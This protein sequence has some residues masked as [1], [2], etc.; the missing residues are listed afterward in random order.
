METM[1]E[2]REY[3]EGDSFTQLLN[4]RGQ[5]L[6]KSKRKKL[7]VNEIFAEVWEPAKKQWID[8]CIKLKIG[9]LFFSD[10]RKHFQTDNLEK[11]RLELKKHYKEENADWIDQRIHQ[12]KQY[13]TIC[14]CLDG[15]KA[16][17]KI[18]R[19]YNLKGNF[20]Q[21]QDIMKLTGNANTKMKTLDEDLLKTCSVL[22]EVDS[23]KAACL[24]M[25]VEC[26]N[27]ILWLRQSMCSIK[28]L[29]VFVDLASTSTGEGDMAVARV[30]CLHSATT[31]YGP[32]IFNFNENCDDK[33]F[34]EKC[35]QV[36]RVL[37]TDSKL[38]KKLRGTY[39]NLE[40]LKSV[41]KSHGSV[42]V[43]S[44]A[45]AE[46]INTSGVYEVGYSGVDT[47]VKKLLLT[48]VLK[49]SVSQEKENDACKEELEMNS[50]ER[51]ETF[52]SK[53]EEKK[54]YNYQQLQDLQS[55]LML[56][57][58]KAEK[59][60]DEVERFT[61]ILDSVVRLG[62]IYTKLVSDGCVL[63]AN[64]KATFLCDKKRAV[65]VFINFGHGIQMQT[66]KG[67]TNDVSSIIPK[68]AE[69]LEHCHR[70]WLTYI[71]EKR[72]QHYLLNYYTIDQI[73][74]L[75]QELVKM[76]LEQNLTDLIYPMLSAVK[77]NCTKED[78]IKAL[79]MAKHDVIQKESSANANLAADSESEILAE[80]E[81]DETAEALL[82]Q[83]IDNGYPEELAREA[84]KHC[85]E[86]LEEALLWCDDHEDDNIIKVTQEQIDVVSADKL[87][88]ETPYSGWQNAF[89]KLHSALQDLWDKFLNSVSSSVS[90]YL[91]AEHLGLILERLAEQETVTIERT[92]PAYFKLGEPNLVIV[93][94][95]EIYNTCLSIYNHE[96]EKPLPQSDEVLLCSPSTTLDMVEIFWR[97]ALFAEN[98]KI[99]C[100][101]NADLLDY[102][103]A[104]R[105]ERNLQSLMTSLKSKAKKY[106]LVILCCAEN[107]NKSV[108]VRALCKFQRPQLFAVEI[109]NVKQYLLGMLKVEEPVHGIKPAAGV[110]FERHCGIR[111]PSWSELH[112]FVS[113]LDAQLQDFEVSSFCSSV[114]LQDLPGFPKFVLRFLIQMSRDF[115]TRS[116]VVSEESPTQVFQVIQENEPQEENDGIIE[117]YQMRRTWESSPHPYLFFNPDHHSMTFLGFNIEKGTGNLIDLQTKEVL[118][119]N[120]MEK[121][122]FDALIR[123]RVNLS[124]N[125]DS[126]PR[127]EKILKLCNVMGIDLAHDPDPTYELTTDNVKKILAIYMRFRCRIPVIIMGE[128]GC[129]KTR[130]IKFMCSLQQPPGVEVKNMILM[131]VHGGT[132]AC[133]IIRKVKQAEKITARNSKQH[134]N[135]DTVLFF[136][137][138][139]TTEAIGVIKEIMCDK[140]LG[141]KPMELHQRLKMVAACNPY[142]KHSK[143][144]IQ[145][146]EQAGLG[147]HV[148]AEKTTDKLGHVPMRNLVYR[149]QP[150]PQS[151]LPLVWDFGQLDT[152]VEELY[153]RQMVLRCV[154]NGHLPSL[155]GL[156]KIVSKILTVSQDFMRKQKDECSF[157]SLRDV[158]RVLQVMSWFY[159]QSQDE[160]HLL[161]NEIRF[162]ERKKNQKAG[163]ESIKDIEDK[164]KQR[165]D[166]IDDL[167]RSLVLALGVCYHACL[168]K[169][170]EYR[171]TVARH[172]KTPLNLP[173]GADQIEEEIL[174]CQSAFID[175]VELAQNI[176]KNKALKENVFMMIICIEL[177]IPMFLVGKPGSSKSLA[178]TIVADAMQ[179]NGAHN[180]L[181]RNFKQVQIVSFQCSP[182]STPDGI[183]GTFKQCAAYQKDK[184]G[185]VSVVVLDE[186]GLAEDSP[187]MPLKTLH[188]LLEDGCCD[189]EEPE[190]Y[191]KVAFV[192]IS[193]WALDP[194]KMN[195]GILVQRDIPDK[196]EL[197]NSARKICST[198]KNVKRIIDPMIDPL[199]ISY[200]ELF[201]QASEEMRE[202]FGLRDFYS[203]LKMLYGFISKSRSKPTWL[204]LK[205]CILRNFGGLPEE[206]I[207]PVDIFARNLAEVVNR[208]EEETEYDPECS[209]T[210]MIKACLSGQADSESRYLLLLTENYGALSILQQKI[211]SMHN[212]EVIFGSSFPSDQEYT[213][214]CR[215]INRIKVC[216]ETGSTVIL[217]NLEN[218]YESLYD[219]LNQYYVE[220]GGERYVDLG[221]GTHRV[222][223]RVHKKFRLVVVAEKQVVYDK[224][225]IP[226][227]NRLEKHFLS[228][229]TMLTGEQAELTEALTEWAETCAADKS[230]NQI[231][232]K[233]V[234]KKIGDTFIG[235]HADTCAA[236][237]H[238]ICEKRKSTTQTIH[239]EREQILKEGKSTLLW[240]A[241]PAAVTQNGGGEEME[242]YSKQQQH[243]SLTDY[244]C[245]RLQDDP[246]QSF[247]AQITTNSRILSQAECEDLCESIPIDRQNVIS[248]TLQQF[249]TEQQFSKQ[250]RSLGDSKTVSNS[251]LIVQCE[252]GD[253]NTE[254]I[255]CARYSIQRELKRILEENSEVKVHVVLLVQ[256]PGIA[257]DSFTGFQCGLWHS[258]HID[259]LRISTVIPP[260]C[261]MCDKSAGEILSS[262]KQ[263][264]KQTSEKVETLEESE[265]QTYEGDKY[266]PELFEQKEFH[267]NKF[268]RSCV[269]KALACLKDPPTDSGHTSGRTTE[270]LNI[271]LRLLE[272]SHEER[273]TVLSGIAEHTN[274]IIR[275]REENFDTTTSS[276]WLS[277]LASRPENITK[278]GTFR[279]CVSQFLESKVVPILAGII[280]FIDTNRN[281]DILIRNEEQKQKWQT[282]LWL[283]I[284]NDPELTQLNYT[285]IVS[286]KQQQELSEYVVK[287]TSSTGRVFSAVMPFSWL[288]YNQI[289]EVLV[290]TKKTLQESDDLINVALKAADIFQDFPLGRLLLSMEEVTTQDILRCYIRDFVFMVYPVQTEN[291]CNLICESVAIECKTLLRGE[292]GRLL[293]S[294]FG[295]HIVYAYQAARFQNFS[296]IVCVWPDCSEKV[297]DYQQRESKNFLVTDEENTL[298][299]LAL[300]LLIDDLKPVKDAL[301][302]PEPR[303]KWLQK[304]CQYRP[305]VERIFGHFKQ[306]VQNQEL[307]YGEQCQQGLQQARYRWTRTFIVKLFIENVCMSNEEEGKEVI[308]CMALWTK[309]GETDPDMKTLTTF[310]TIENYLKKRN[311]TVLS[312]C[313]GILSP[314]LACER[315]ISTL[316]VKLPC[317]DV[318]CEN[319]YR[320]IIIEKKQCIHCNETLPENFNPA[321]LHKS[322]NLTK[323]RD[324]RRRC[325]SF[326]M[327]VVS[328]LCF[329]EGTPPSPDV[330]KKLQSYII[331]K[332]KNERGEKLLVSKE[333]SVFQDSIDPTPVV[334][335][336]LLQQLMQTSGVNVEEHLTSYFE[337]TCQLVETIGKQEELV[338]LCLLILQCMED[339]I[340]QQHHQYCDTAKEI[341]I[342][343]KLMRETYNV[344]CKTDI[345]VLEKIKAIAKT[346]FALSI[347]ANYV[348][349]VF[350]ISQKGI[351]GDLRRLFETAGQLCEDCLCPWPRQ[352]FVKH[353][354]RSFG[355]DTYQAVQGSYDFLRWVQ[356]PDLKGKEVK[357]CHD[358]YIV[359][360]GKY[361]AIREAVVA[362][363]ISQKETELQKILSVQHTDEWRTR[364]MVVLALHRE[365]AMHNIYIDE[366]KF[367][368]KGYDLLK[369]C[370]LKHPS[371]RNREGLPSL[372]MT[373]KLWED[374]RFNIYSEM[375]L[376]QQNIICLLTHYMVLMMEIPGQTTLITPLKNIAL[377]PEKMVNAYYPTMPQDEALYVTEA[378]LQARK[379]NNE[380]P[381]LYKCPNGHPYIIGDCGRPYYK[382]KCNT[383][384]AQI[385]GV[386]HKAIPGN[387]KYEG[388]ETA[389]G[390]ILGRVCDRS[391][392]QAVIHDRSLDKETIILIRLL[393]HMSMFVGCNF[394]SQAVLESIRVNPG[395]ELSEV[396]DFL[397]EHID[398]DIECLHRILGKSR[399]D[400]FLLIHHLLATIME[401]HNMSVIGEAIPVEQCELT[402]K[403][404]RI[405]WEQEFANRYST[406]VL[407]ALTG[408]LKKC[409]N[410]ILK[411]K[412]LGSDPLLQLLYEVDIQVEML[413][414]TNLQNI[415]AVWGYR[416]C[417]SV[418][419]LTQ[420]LNS[421]QQQCPVLSVFLEEE[422]ILRALRHIPSIL[423]LQKLLMNK[424]NRKLD[425]TEGTTLQID[426]IKKDIEKDRR[427]EEFGTLLDDYAEAWECVR[428]SLE[429]YTCSVNGSFVSVNK[430]H[431]RRQI[432]SRT[433]VSFLLPTL[434]DD[435]GLCAYMLLRFLLERQNSFLGKYCQ[436][437]NKLFDSMPRVHVK[438]ISSAHLISYHPDK[439]LL[440]MV[441]ANCNYSFEVGQGTKVEYDFANL[442]R[443]LLDR[444]LFSKSVITGIEEIEMFRYRTESTNA[445]VFDEL[446]Q[447]IKQERINTTIQNQIQSELQAKEFSDLCDSLVKLDIAISFLKSVGS[448]PDSLLF[449]FMSKTLKIQHPFLSSKAQQFTKCK[450]T[451]SWWVTLSLHKEK[452]QAKSKYNQNLFDSLS[453]SFKQPLKSDQLK[454]I[455][456]IVN[457]LPLEHIHIL[458]VLTFECILLRL[459]IPDSDNL[460]EIS[461]QEILIPYIDSSP[462]ENDSLVGEY[463]KEAIKTLPSGKSN[464]KVTTAQIVDFWKTIN[465]LLISKEQFRR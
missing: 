405:K 249:H 389:R 269:L 194:A 229:N 455:E 9:D 103:I 406:P 370:L 224:F 29:Q 398:F 135:M 399:D 225:P 459:D 430:E 93:Q 278:A 116:L 263:E 16:I 307:K 189:D 285:T 53:T 39:E 57:A 109:Q 19:A 43:N 456:G 310:E 70:T 449:D 236:I 68:I 175:N 158:E 1:K 427:S 338:E 64:W 341:T 33:A 11:L 232:Y 48:D 171:R 264:V 397:L 119:K 238:D 41:K 122:L 134:I 414:V 382:D 342:A 450:N 368:D 82:K 275:E 180:D 104:D 85:D 384:G 237:I 6:E 94:E 245:K 247:Y 366:Q 67:K 347:V 51:K 343:T 160:E 268:I 283:Q 251:M 401:K 227:I 417:V 61:M 259:D 146:L 130:L 141:G 297:L 23:E 22:S 280:S 334:R 457:S 289:D 143:E 419:H 304:V 50:E 18:V 444:F 90:D 55:R 178:K 63:F 352:Y 428:Q 202:F 359:C 49:L 363:G 335:S 277:V 462:F 299:I 2:M 212:A 46:A 295:C 421:S 316:P 204:Q 321:E 152:E 464:A 28:E 223:C 91:S 181:F 463:L 159:K 300:Q 394:K 54:K 465:K 274:K 395:V 380:N 10:F 129:G 100:L 458:L 126:L 312:Q 185:F 40:W 279:E 161:F 60:N 410:E 84:L 276:N 323:Y 114:A 211:F 201:D 461:L 416:A 248:L 305:V 301:N 150:L 281:L 424:Y 106:K 125:F 374:Q 151:M 235:Y 446:S 226:L 447:R 110:D 56:V 433:P 373:N 388:D 418:E 197:R 174:N 59:G 219:A 387:V 429:S 371:F 426:T 451:L 246:D 144:L 101:I 396:P 4:S 340:H 308:R 166:G 169:R 432:D 240:C 228:M 20:S 348:E 257:G 147:Y 415:S 445:L 329:A 403:D 131:K 448:N 184:E 176:A 47:P 149:V 107:E 69:F 42:E 364:V 317:N 208:N 30:H 353:L 375:N 214:V 97:R 38:P 360:G 288:I 35:K 74:I 142:R 66:L 362:V 351:P 216:M 81:L 88:E 376:T 113:F 183:V 15:A 270:R 330:I 207:K 145:R 89:K 272:N 440:P 313:F 356:I 439:D 163:R 392:K 132:K 309:L 372:V 271:V 196:E 215:N 191:K 77:H 252:C 346:R 203:L 393:T 355:I 322:E 198:D 165:H 177:K 187:R 115:S 117:Q 326:F 253:Q 255:A 62:N 390:H 192:G 256:L 213:Q 254:L 5:H 385:G 324:F 242:I 111:D 138:A 26:K 349:K 71:T 441:F 205:H 120:I 83:I 311:D 267:I 250:I 218:L 92:L 328:Q 156:D 369:E 350:R 409:N 320:D 76:G 112:H 34:L 17:M 319:C 98:D 422:S 123:N 80:V 8:Q 231:G 124:E 314:C 128:T 402:K 379:S 296:H 431:L 460:A 234:E 87:L 105:A 287:T 217:L 454:I 31:G 391:Q 437:S 273:K 243:E 75:Q 361:K 337:S 220:F 400:V 32:L 345:G 241:T 96:D 365:V 44:L 327:E 7:S 383:C 157:V 436:K 193:N 293:P 36:W 188:P 292:Y 381:V 167:T 386:G 298:D 172:F 73:V 162:Q 336:F 58:G 95:N 290:N 291:E 315:K 168:K 420:M 284:I 139:N 137:E 182:L 206:V 72:E 260:L 258:V 358:R 153:I 221:L 294:L 24:N 102:D 79:S 37:S 261:D 140:T 244:L 435:G 332:S 210:G 412:R 179:G 155:P 27:L 344:I 148:D 452:Q 65:C 173:A 136:D 331:G 443:Q 190:P 3:T 186:I 13:K 407:K 265:L 354:C 442:E 423:R 200:N 302:K 209:S 282:E 199:A 339:S 266:E 378:L 408:T 306:D 377:F 438:D 121:N 86:D 404:G 52:V 108:I 411:D 154:N 367:S 239:N 303:N 21:I 230:P 318:Y 262:S 133:D 25:F 14:N 413:D 357:E 78:L 286:P 12:F 99:Y 118:E 453:D 195:R 45:Q 164:L 333:L 325:N 434:R 425:K 127:H 233:K 222:K 170:K